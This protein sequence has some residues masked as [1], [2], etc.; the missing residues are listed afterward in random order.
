MS[1][2]PRPK[3]WD[4]GIVLPQQDT[5][6][7]CWACA[8]A[9]LLGYLKV[10]PAP[11]Q[12][13]VRK[14]FLGTGDQPIPWRDVAKA[15]EAYG[16]T[17]IGPDAPLSEETLWGEVTPAVCRPVLIGYQ[18]NRGGGHVAIVTG[19]KEWTQRFLVQDPVWGA[20]ELAYS[21]IRAAYGLGQWVTSWGRFS[22]TKVKS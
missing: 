17:G 6:E 4:C 3:T 5:A 21:E 18:W 15:F 19:A 7:D 2:P 8:I 14:R 16:V 20:A 12:D 22:F 9:G 1:L 10:D 11:S 13:D